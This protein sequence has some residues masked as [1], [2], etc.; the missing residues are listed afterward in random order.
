[1]ATRSQ[2][3]EVKS[4]DIADF[5]TRDVSD[6]SEE[7]D[8][9]IVVDE[10]GTS[11]EP[12]SSVSELAF[13]SSDGLS[14]GNSFNIVVGTELLQEGNDVLGLFNTFDLVID[15]Q[16]KVRDILDSVASSKDERNQSRSSQSR[17]NSVSLLL[18]VDLSV[19]SSPSLEGSEHATFS[20]RVGEGTLS[21]SGS[22]TSTDSWYSCDGTTGSP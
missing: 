12:I 1:M 17:G 22:T 2:L 21:G 8:V 7:V 9:F 4:V 13:T 5:N 18:D 10:Q 11:T 3:S 19:P 14:V 20:T 15:N 6:S 16:R